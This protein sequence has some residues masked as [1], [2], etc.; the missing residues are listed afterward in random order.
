MFRSAA[1]MGLEQMMSNFFMKRSSRSEQRFIHLHV[2]LV[3]D[4]GLGVESGLD[5]SLTEAVQ[6]VAVV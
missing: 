5:S 1:N 4:F 6:A 2:N 3:C